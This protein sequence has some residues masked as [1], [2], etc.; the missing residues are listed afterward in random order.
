MQSGTPVVAKII[1]SNHTFNHGER[2]AY[3]DDLLEKQGD[4]ADK[5]KPKFKVE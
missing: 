4:N 5:V 2:W 3:I 1:E